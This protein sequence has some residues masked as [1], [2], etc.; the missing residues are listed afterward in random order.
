M[1]YR[2]TYFTTNNES[3]LLAFLLVCGFLGLFVVLGF[4]FT[5]GLGFALGGVLGLFI[6]FLNNYRL[7]FLGFYSS[8]SS[9]P[10]SSSMPPK[11]NP[12]KLLTPKNISME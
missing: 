3:L 11:S 6:I 5:L 8:S 12:S 7:T 10:S 1:K 9:S 2:K 4:G